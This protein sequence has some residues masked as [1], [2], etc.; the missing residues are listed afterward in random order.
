M[1]K[2]P[3]EDSYCYSPGRPNGIFAVARTMLCVYTVICWFRPDLSSCN[4]WWN[5]GQAS[6]IMAHYDYWEEENKDWHSILIDSG[7]TWFSC[8]P[9][10][11]E[12][13]IIGGAEARQLESP[14]RQRN[15]LRGRRQIVYKCRDLSR[16]LR[17]DHTTSFFLIWRVQADK[18]AYAKKL[19]HPVSEYR[20][21][22]QN[23]GRR[24]L[25][26]K[27]YMSNHPPALHLL[28]Q[29]GGG[30]EWTMYDLPYVIEIIIIPCIWE[31]TMN[32][33]IRGN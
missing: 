13:S 9:T 26:N 3:P 29:R 17:A 4:P 18:L 28:H 7:A 23:H 12:H 10:D 20:S 24:I 11:G 30:G 33:C 27:G 19:C 31:K 8:F 6:D 1:Q 22:W 15:Y 2:A 32:S 25:R 5:Q 14:V 16:A 21:L